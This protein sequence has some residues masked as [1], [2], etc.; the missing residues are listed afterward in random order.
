MANFNP[1]H[2]NMKRKMYCVYFTRKYFLCC[3][4]LIV[5]AQ[6][7]QRNLQA[8]ELELYFVQVIDIKVGVQHEIIS[9]FVYKY[10]H[11]ELN[12]IQENIFDKPNL[13]TWSHDPF[14]PLQA[15]RSLGCRVCHGTPRFWQISKP[16]LNQEGQFMPTT[17]LLAPSDFQTFLRPCLS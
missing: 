16:F 1:F 9:I 14:V 15:C 8:T 7:N 5:I 6:S 13:C 11:G 17:L 3:Y 12:F 10:S 4:N 2:T